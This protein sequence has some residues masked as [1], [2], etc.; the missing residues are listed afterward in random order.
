MDFLVGGRPGDGFDDVIEI[1]VHVGLAVLEIDHVDD[2]DLIRVEGIEGVDREVLFRDAGRR[3][4]DAI[5][6]LV[7]GALGHDRGKGDVAGI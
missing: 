3:G 6:F 4:K 5:E 1:D 2:F 7:L